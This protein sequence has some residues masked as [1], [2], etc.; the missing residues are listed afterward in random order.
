MM[1]V[2]HRAKRLY[3]HRRKGITQRPQITTHWG[4]LSRCDACRADRFELFALNGQF[5]CKDCYIGA[6]TEE[7]MLKLE[8]E[9][10]AAASSLPF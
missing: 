8:G 5:L 9:L 7:W 10:K 1:L 4:D 3:I 2:A 6:R